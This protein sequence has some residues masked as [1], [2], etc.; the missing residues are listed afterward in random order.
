MCSPP[1]QRVSAEKVLNAL[2]EH[3]DTWTRVDGIL[4]RATNTQTK[5]FA[6]QVSGAI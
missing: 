3:P 1:P 4:E 6:L 5:F 2:K